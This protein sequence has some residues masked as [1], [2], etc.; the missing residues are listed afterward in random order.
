MGIEDKVAF[1]REALQRLE[2]LPQHSLEQ[3][4][5]DDRNLASALHWLQTAIQALVDI[6]LLIVSSRGLPTPRS[7][8]EVLERL[9]SADLLPPG[10]ALRFR[11]IVGFR[12][13]VVHLY[14][15][16]DPE[17]VYRVV[18][19]DRRDLFA[20]LN[21]LLAAASATEATDG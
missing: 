9:E 7:S 8:G 16:I 6:G 17:I 18:R 3:S 1:V 20:L 12:N 4:L 5:A 13:R 14:D 21:A 10:S 2:E 19:R 15:R 11:P